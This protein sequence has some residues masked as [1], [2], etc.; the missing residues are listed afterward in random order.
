MLTMAT[1]DDTTRCSHF[2]TPSGADEHYLT[3]PGIAVLP[4]DT[5][6]EDLTQRYEIALSERGLSDDTVVFFRL[7][8][9]DLQNYQAAII[10]SPLGGVWADRY[11]KR[12]VLLLSLAVQIALAFTLYS[13][14][15]SGQITVPI[16]LGL[17]AAMGFA[18]QVNLSAYQAFVAEI[19]SPRAK[20]A[21]VQITPEELDAS[22]ESLG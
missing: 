13:V 21:P 4:F 20:R 22:L 12:A 8:V 15:R 9:S 5:T 11:S 2:A 18:S 10:A 1:I 6:L 14:S 19:V 17:A 3:I 7:F 16:L